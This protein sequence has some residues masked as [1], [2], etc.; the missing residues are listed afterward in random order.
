MTSALGRSQGPEAALAIQGPEGKQAP[1]AK[2]LSF[3]L[4]G[5]LGA[6]LGRARLTGRNGV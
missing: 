4:F 2:P 1:D 3:W 6:S 5:G